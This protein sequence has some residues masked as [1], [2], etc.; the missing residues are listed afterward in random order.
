MSFP[1]AK[2]YEPKS[3]LMQWIDQRLP[4]PRLVWNSVGGGYE[5]PRNLNY[6][7]NFAV[8]A[9]FALMMQIVTGIV[10]AMHYSPSGPIAF[11]SVEHIMRHAQPRAPPTGA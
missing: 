9:G 2:P 8:L 3:G 1:W 4:L 6:M 11:Q 10:L 7:W 5:V